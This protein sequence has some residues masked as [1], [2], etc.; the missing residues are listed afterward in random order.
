MTSTLT[1]ITFVNEHS[2]ATI[3][4]RAMFEWKN[5]L[6]LLPT[7]GGGVSMNLQNSWSFS[8]LYIYISLIIHN[9][10]DGMFE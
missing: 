2:Y 3:K 6:N 1:I 10:I 4:S 7:E 8:Y 5:N 9:S